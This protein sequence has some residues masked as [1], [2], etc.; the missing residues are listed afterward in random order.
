MR[1]RLK[2]W[3]VPR[4][5]IFDTVSSRKGVYANYIWDFNRKKESWGEVGQYDVA[6]CIE[7]TDHF[8]DPV[9][10]FWNIHE[11]LRP[12]GMLY[13]SSNFLFPHHTGFDCIRL[14]ATGLRKILTENGFEVVSVLP[15]M[16]A[17]QD[18]LEEAMR[19]ESKV[20]NHPGEIGYMVTAKRL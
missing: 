1:G 12:G 15:R 16:A 18:I 2:K 14:T 3:D 9:T 20:Y 17:K 4:Y 11:L 13:V 5:D 8:W 10:A 6:F 19:A 7:V